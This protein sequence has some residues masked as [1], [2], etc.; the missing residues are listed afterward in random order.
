ME[1]KE[2]D[3]ITLTCPFCKKK[4][5]EKTPKILS[6]ETKIC[7]ITWLELKETAM[8]EEFDKSDKFNSYTVEEQKLVKNLIAAQKVQGET[9]PFPA[10]DPQLHKVSQHGN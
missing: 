5:V 8:A 6:D 10:L 4:H 3:S 9:E 1:D 7:D 2:P